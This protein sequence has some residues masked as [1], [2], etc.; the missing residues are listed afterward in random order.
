MKMINSKNFLLIGIVAFIYYITGVASFELFSSNKI[1]TIGLFMPEGFALAFSLYF[2]KKVIPGI[3]LGQFFLAYLNNMPF[4]TSLFIG[5]INSLEA[6]LAIFLFQKFNLS[7]QLKTFKDIFGL[8]GLIVFFLQPF[9]AIASNLF[10]SLG[11]DLSFHHFLVSTFSWWF[12]NVMGQLLFTPFLLLLFQKYKSID[13][14]NLLFYGLLY[15]IFLYLLEIVF[16][17][18]NSFMLMSLSISVIIFTLT[19]KGLFYG[20]FLTVIATIVSSISIYLQVGAFNF[21]TL[22]NNTIDFNLFLLSHIVIVW[23]FGILFE[24]KRQHEQTLQER[25]EKEVQKNKEQQLLMLQQNR[26]AQQ[27]ELIS[28]IAHQW[29]QPLNNLSL[30]SQLLVSKYYKNKLDDE[31][32]EYFQKNSKKQIE[33]M[34]RTIDDFRNFFKDEESKKEFSVNDV[35]EDTIEMIKPITQKNNISITFKA[36]KNFQVLGFLNNFSQVLL[37]ILNNAKDALSDQEIENK[38]ILITLKQ[39]D[40]KVLLC[41]EDNAGG[42]KEE[43]LDKIFDPYFSTKKEKN[44][45]GLGLYMSK[46]IIQDQMNGKLFVQ[47]T[48]NG[49]KFTISI[50]GIKYDK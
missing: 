13:Y 12:G 6:L 26:L 5:T 22:I 28:M 11:N 46:I 7:T 4:F 39:N 10:L 34:S 14:K 44:G 43:L 17:I 16:I 23:V 37:N 21:G 19:Y 8:A 38:N 49:A 36:E 47:N 45:T 48:P 9:S 1:I 35:V 15:A 27:G 42:I 41:I 20:S 32:I 24:E 40:N 33:L 29:R 18:E 30:L 3:F 25:I 31:A 50:E 2:G